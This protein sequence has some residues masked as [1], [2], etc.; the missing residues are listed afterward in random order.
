M[1]LCAYV[2][3][4][5]TVIS[6][7]LAVSFIFIHELWHY[8]WCWVCL[9]YNDGEWGQ[10]TTSYQGEQ[11]KRVRVWRTGA[12]RKQIS[13]CSRVLC[14]PHHLLRLLADCC[15]LLPTLLLDPTHK[16]FL[17]STPCQWIT[18]T[19]VTSSVACPFWGTGL[20][21]CFITGLVSKMSFSAS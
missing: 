15:A 18:D 21:S 9:A 6:G 7:V 4:K 10:A 5:R 8:Q 3:R 19:L 13:S 2:F 20:G 12:R 17:K 11:A 1:Y 14:Y 16:S